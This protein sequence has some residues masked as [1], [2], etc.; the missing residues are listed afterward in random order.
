M[1]DGTQSLEILNKLDHLESLQFSL[2]TS[3]LYPVLFPLVYQDW[4]GDT[5]HNTSRWMPPNI[6]LTWPYVQGSAAFHELYV[7]LLILNFAN[8]LLKRYISLHLPVVMVLV[9]TINNN[10]LF[11]VRGQLCKVIR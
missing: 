4:N 10:A 11:M 3:R 1:N 8:L 2:D 9:A 7:N 6:R 5:T